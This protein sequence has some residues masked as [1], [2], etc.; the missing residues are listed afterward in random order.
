[1]DYFY[2]PRE[3]SNAGVKEYWIVD[4]EKNHVSVYNFEKNMVDMYSFTDTIKSV[5]FDGLELNLKELKEYLD[6]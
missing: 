2:K 5:L 1:M 6:S 4:F 3:Y